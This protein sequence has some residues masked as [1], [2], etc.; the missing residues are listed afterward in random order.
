MSDNE[1][2]N[3]NEEALKNYQKL[4]RTQTTLTALT[5]S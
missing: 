2:L 1:N 3:N 5:L 4:I